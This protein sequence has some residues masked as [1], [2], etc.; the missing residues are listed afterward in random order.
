[1][2]RN[3]FGVGGISP[4]LPRVGVS[5]RQPW[6]GGRNAFGVEFNFLSSS[7]VP[8]ASRRGWLRHFGVEFN[9][10]NPGP[11]PGSGFTSA[12]DP[13]VERFAFNPRLISL[14]PAGV[15][16]AKTNLPAFR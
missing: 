10:V 3:P 11:L 7:D 13:G 14:T 2:G 6:A 15:R 1:M 16:I 9:S 4:Q 5:T 8:R 12:S